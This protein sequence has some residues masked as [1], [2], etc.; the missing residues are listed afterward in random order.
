MIDTVLTDKEK[1]YLLKY[2]LSYSNNG[3]EEQIIDR[4]GWAHKGYRLTIAQP[5][6]TLDE[7]NLV[8]KAKKFYFPEFFE[9]S[10]E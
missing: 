8:R 3:V 7:I 1:D 4:D 5:I 9:N 10:E 2:I 6:L